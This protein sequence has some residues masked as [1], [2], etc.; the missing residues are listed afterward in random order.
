MIDAKYLVGFDA[1][2]THCRARLTDMSGKLLGEG[3]SGAATTRMGASA[4]HSSIETCWRLAFQHAGLPERAG[5]QTLACIGIAGFNRK[6]VIAEMEAMGFPFLSARFVSDAEI[7]NTG[8]HNGRDGA[9]VIIGTGSIGWGKV[10]DQTLR[11]GGYGFPIS[12][13]GSGA[14]IGLR[15]IRACLQAHDGRI[16]MGP[17]CD[18]V[19]RSFDSNPAK[20]VAWMDSA[21][22]TEYGRLAKVV[23]EHAK[24]GEPLA[25]RLLSDAAM[26]IA[27]IVR[28]LSKQGAP[29]IALVGGLAPILQAYIPDDIVP[30]LCPAAGDAIDGALLIARRLRP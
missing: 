14:D 20:A 29:S 28:A 23:Y 13:E 19:L 4:A 1:G 5:A 10:A 17:L 2:G 30:L 25:Q 12:D 24:A 3:V 27:R 18:E 26:Q 7:A 6:S 11:V 8:A 9:I 16:P 21:S 15:V 22:A